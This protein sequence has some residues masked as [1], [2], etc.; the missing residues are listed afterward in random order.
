MLSVLARSWLLSI[1]LALALLAP[2][3]A[4][5]D[6]RLARHRPF[7][8]IVVFGDSLSD[9]GNVFALNGGQTVAPPDYGMGGVDSQGIPEVIALIPEA[10]YTS[11]HF[12]NGVTWIELL[13]GVIG[14]GSNARPAVPGALFG[15]DDGRA[16]N[17]AV[18]GA[19]AANLGVSQFPLG[20]QV[21]LFLSDV[22]GSAPSNALYVIAIGG[23]DIR[24]ALAL[25]PGVLNMALASVGENIA[26]LHQAGARKFLIWN[27]PNLG[28]TPAIQRLDPFVCAAVVAPAGC[29]IGSA[30]QASAG[31]NAGLDAVLQQV[32]AL[33]DIGIVQF[34]LFGSLEAIV[35]N[36]G[37]FGLKDATTAC[38][39]PNVPPLFRC[40]QPDRHL[41]WDGI[42]PTRA[43]H[44]ILAFLVGKTLVTAILHDD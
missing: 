36:P 20:T 26:R 17:Y 27:A 32:G 28:R 34:D 5:A 13:A 2:E 1:V 7:D 29:L 41:F 10:P 18:G 19:T 6:D 39:Q 15:T 42:H 25:G 38:I 3:R 40:A 35:A 16:S 8:R 44:A 31:Y 30:A 11:R 22:R 21:D 9:P 24:A 37:R 33:P 12:S 14:L 43:G 23:N 4:A